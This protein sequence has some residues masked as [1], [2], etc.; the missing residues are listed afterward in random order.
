MTSVL[1]RVSIV[2]TDTSVKNLL[3][4]YLEFYLRHYLDRDY[5]VCTKLLTL[6]LGTLMRIFYFDE[7]NDPELILGID[8]THTIESY[9]DPSFTHFDQAAANERNPLN[10]AFKNKHP[11]PAQ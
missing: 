6:G 3:K 8:F 9:I 10:Q 7:G 1:D 2:P 4:N 11:K 5:S